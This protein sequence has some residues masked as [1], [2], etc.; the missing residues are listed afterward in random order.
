MGN[1]IESRLPFVDYELVEL[2]LALPDGLKLR[3]GHTKW[4]L[5]SV[6]KGLLPA[7]IH[8]ARFKRGFDVDARWTERAFAPALREGLRSSGSRVAEWLAPG[9]DVDTAFSDDALRR[10]PQAFAEGVTLAW[11]A[12]ADGPEAQPAEHSLEPLGAAR[13]R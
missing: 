6:A 1:S 11:L 8:D 7:E 12:G 2:A 4:A 3:G 13:A 5:R 10:R 9:T